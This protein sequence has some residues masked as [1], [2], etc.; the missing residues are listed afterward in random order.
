LELRPAAL[1]E[2]LAVALRGVRRSGVG[3]G[4]RVLVTGG[5]PIGVLTVAVLRALGIED[6]TVSEPAETRRQLARKVGAATTVLPGELGEPA[7]PMDLI[8]APFDAAIECSGRP[9]A[10]T[11]GLASLGRGGVLVLSGTGMNRPRLDTLRVIL[12]ELVITG[13][14]EYTRDD[15]DAAIALLADDQVPSDV[16]IE[17]L[18]VP[19]SG[20]QRAMER[21]AAG[22]VAGKVMVAPRA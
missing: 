3:P 21:L 4:G 2:P 13:S 15:F 10:M 18:D 20:V 11:A 14:M 9:E 19:L 12:N 5:G 1:T 22:E 6:I 7:L 8:D 17:P 16:L